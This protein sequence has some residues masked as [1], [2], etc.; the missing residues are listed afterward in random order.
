MS[1]GLKTRELRKIGKSDPGGLLTRTVPLAENNG[2]WPVRIVDR[3]VTHT[4]S[5]RGMKIVKT[6]DCVNMHYENGWS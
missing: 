4:L 3:K 1:F 5:I 2:K 6:V